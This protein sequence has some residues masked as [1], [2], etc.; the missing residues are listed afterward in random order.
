MEDDRLPYRKAIPVIG[1]VSSGKST[2]LNS[3]LGIEIL[4]AKDDITTKFVCIIR[5][6]PKLKNPIFYHV[7]LEKYET[8]EDYYY[9]KDGK[10]AEGFNQIKDMISKINDS[11]KDENVEP[12]YDN[13]FYVLETDI[14]NIKNK[15][16]LNQFDFYDIP[17]LNEYIKNNENDKKNADKI[18]KN[19]IK[20]IK[21]QNIIEDNL[22]MKEN[23]GENENLSEAPPTESKKSTKGTD[24]E[25]ESEKIKENMKYIKGI[26]QFIK[27]KIDF[28]IIIID[29]CQ[30]YK[31]QNIQIIK[32][33]HDN[34][35]I[36]FQNFLFV[37]NK[38]DL[39]DDP[40]EAEQACRN[41]FVQRLD[42]N[43]FNINFNVFVKINSFQL[44]NEINM[45]KDFKYF[46][47]YYFNK[48]ISDFKK[49][50]SATPSG[51]EN[52][53]SFTFIAFISS[54]ITKFIQNKEQYLKELAEKVQDDEFQQVIKIYEEIKNE[55]SEIINFGIDLEKTEEDEEDKE[56]EKEDNQSILTL[57]AFYQSFK[58]KQLVPKY[59]DDVQTIIDFFNDFTKKDNETETNMPPSL[60]NEEEAISKFKLV[61][62]GLKKYKTDE[63]NVVELLSLDLNKLEKIIYNKKKIYIPFIGVSSAGK[64]TIL[65]CIVGDYIFPESQKECTTKGIILQHNFKDETELFETDMDPSC[66]YY[67]FKERNSRPVAKG[68]YEVIKYLKTLNSFYSKNENKHFFILKTPIKLFDILNLSD[69]LKKRTSFIDLPGGDTDENAFNQLGKEGEM[70]IYQ[71]LIHISTSFC[72]INKGRAIGLAQNYDVF[73]KLFNESH[74]HSQIINEKDF[75]KNCLFVLNEFT[76]LSPEEKNITKIKMDIEQVLYNTNQNK[77]LEKS[78]NVTIFNALKYSQYLNAHKSYTNLSWLF[79][80]VT[81]S[82]LNQFDF[83]IGIKLFQ[84]TNYV[85][86]AY[87]NIKKRI[88]SITDNI[89]EKKKCTDDFLCIVKS[90][91]LDE[92]QSLH[93]D[94]SNKDNTTIKKISNILYNFIEN[95]KQ[96]KFYKESFCEDFF[97]QLYNQI[98]N[99]DA[100]LKKQYNEYLGESFDYLD[101]FFNQDFEQKKNIK[102]EDI[103]KLYKNIEP[104]IEDIFNKYNFENIF[105]KYE[106]KIIIYLKAKKGD[107]E[108]ILEDH[109]NNVNKALESITPGLQELI[110]SFQ[111][112]INENVEGL[113]NDI[114]MFKKKAKEI[115]HKAYESSSEKLGVKTEMSLGELDTSFLEVLYNNLGIVGGVVAGGIGASLAVAIFGLNMIPG[116]GTVISLIAGVGILII[117]AIFGPSKKKKFQNAIDKII[118]NINEGF[119]KQKNIL[120]RTLNKLENKLTKDMK[121]EIGIIA[122]HLEEGEKKEFEENKTLYF[123]IKE[124]L[125][126]SE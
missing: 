10:T 63:E 79:K 125:L 27:N 23:Q 66:D 70:T 18:D 108:N 22:E 3:L 73:R 71:K 54:E 100:L 62:E 76:I 88:K 92:L 55:Q 17:G 113:G 119:R 44:K 87:D 118:K 65:N 34:V 68:K 8:S 122:F 58:E 126:N 43:T 30:H 11:N 124:I 46:F 1:M 74:M 16:F 9:I 109:D 103:N 104:E 60:T 99:S 78:I 41:Y 75:L 110:T 25:T 36:E 50:K 61:F 98:L 37:L 120:I 112:E 57:K 14:T 19:E 12:Q 85:K 6:N 81:K 117:G 86:F 47:R 39:V 59:S 20:E 28:G 95:I 69:D 56:E 89:D 35:N 83:G 80:S 51:E 107:A 29:S 42:S 115:I 5:Y 82:Y 114:E 67:V 48:Y 40:E 26:F 101:K 105:Q 123:E 33:L 24:E 106:D 32:E 72:F 94:S 91:I 111:K 93:R 97:N 52:L 121:T 77:E 7:K 102:T 13:L 96:I 2:F 21:K 64:S 53:D 45:D 31:P 4:E 90:L 116:I 38:I 15:D 49:L 84:E